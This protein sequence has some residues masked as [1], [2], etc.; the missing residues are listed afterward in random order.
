MAENQNN[1]NDHNDHIDQNINNSSFAAAEQRVM[2][3]SRMARQF[4]DMSNGVRENSSP[5]ASE[6]PPVQE[7]E[8]VR[9]S[10]K[11]PPRELLPGISL[12]NV[13]TEKVLLAALMLLLVSEGA[14]FVLIA[15]LVYVMM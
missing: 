11:D 4:T 8:N 9:Q 10:A 6:A 13:D 12:K 2:N 3:R 14:D 15:A 1:R 5:P 7:R